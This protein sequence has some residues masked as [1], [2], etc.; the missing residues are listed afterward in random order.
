MFMAF[1]LQIVK[2]IKI[3]TQRLDFHCL[4]II[5]YERI[6]PG[7]DFIVFYYYNDLNSSSRARFSLLSIKS[8]K[9]KYWDSSPRARFVLLFRSA[10]DMEI[11][12]PGLDD[13]CFLIQRLYKWYLN[14]SP[15]A[16]FSLLFNENLWRILDF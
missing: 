13:H 6:N 7:L 11:L 1:Y 3:L 14:S 9:K 5:N 2:H 8:I 4:L 12:A 16:R 15:R 10:E